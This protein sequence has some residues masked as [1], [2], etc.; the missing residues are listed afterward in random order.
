[1]KKLTAFVVGVSLVAGAAVWAANTATSV[2]AVGF[3]TVTMP[4]SGGFALVALNFDQVGGSNEIS[5]IDLLGTN[6]LRAATA[7]QNADRVHLYDVAS[8]KYYRY[9]FKQADLAFHEISPVNKWNLA[10]TNPVI[11]SGQGFWLQSGINYL[12][13]NYVTLA[14]QV[15]MSSNSVVNIAVGFQMLGSD[16]SVAVNITTQFPYAV[17]ATAPQ[18]ADQLSLYRNGAYIRYAK[19]TADGLWHQISPV[20]KWNLAGETNVT[21]QVGEGFWYKAMQS[22]SATSSIPYSL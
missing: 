8:Q 7:P 17:S 6:Q 4:P 15:P 14:G 16:Y 12:S 5:L 10:S 13:T 19:K 21:V 20:N 1:M 18:N 22:S 9:A 2:N 3:V 11:S